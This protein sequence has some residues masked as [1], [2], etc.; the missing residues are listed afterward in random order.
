MQA[1][2]HAVASTLF[3]PDSEYQP[4]GRLSPEGIA[5]VVDL[6]NTSRAKTRTVEPVTEMIDYRYLP[7]AGS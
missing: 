3:G 7:I 2:V 5:V 4:D 6:C 1:D